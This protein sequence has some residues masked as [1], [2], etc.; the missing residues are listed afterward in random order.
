M[1]SSKMD[2]FGNFGTESSSDFMCYNGFRFTIT[3]DGNADAGNRRIS[4]IAEPVNNDD[5]TS[6]IYIDKKI[7]EMTPKFSHDKLRRDFVSME[8]DFK[9][10]IESLTKDIANLQEQYE[11]QS[12]AFQKIKSLEFDNINLNLQPTT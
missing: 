2:K 10:K 9:K 5:V 4:N 3:F 12:K 1:L 6:K 8:M 7:E 11:L